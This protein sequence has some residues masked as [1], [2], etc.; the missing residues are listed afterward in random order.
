MAAFNN[1]LLITAT[2]EIDEAHLIETA[3]AR[4]QARYGA[5]A[6]EG[7]VS[8]FADRCRTIAEALRSRWRRDHGLSDET[9][10]VTAFGK[11]QDGLRR[12]AF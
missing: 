11:Q 4:A 8:Y 2:G 6:T 9:V 1:D 3:G 7:D 12:S 5:E 10:M